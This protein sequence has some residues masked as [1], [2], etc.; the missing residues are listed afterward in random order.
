[1]LEDQHADSKIDRKKPPLTYLL[2]LGYD[3]VGLTYEKDHPGGVAGNHFK[4]MET[5]SRE[6]SKSIIGIA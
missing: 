2:T 4:G 5:G 3:I 1:M 6:I